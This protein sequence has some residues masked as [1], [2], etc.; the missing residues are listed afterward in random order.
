MQPRQGSSGAVAMARRL[1][2]SMPWLKRPLVGLWGLV[3]GRREKLRHQVS[4][5]SYQSTLWEWRY[6]A[7]ANEHWGPPV[8]PPPAPRSLP[9]E[10][11]DRFTMNGRIPVREQLG[12][13]TYPSNHPL[14]YTDAEIDY[15]IS[16][17]KAGAPF[18]YLGADIWLREAMSKYPVA[19]QSIAVMGS[20]TPW[21]EATCLAFGGRPFTIDYN[22]IIS[23]SARLEVATVAEFERNPR[24]F[25]AALTISSFEHD[26]LGMYGDPIDP[27]GDLKTMAKM[28]TVVKPG[29]LMYFSVPM[30]RD[31]LNFNVCRV[32]GRLRLPLMLR[33]WDV[34]DRFGFEDWHLDVDSA[35]EPIFVLR[36]APQ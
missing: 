23:K 11:L 15:Y 25:D 35:V 31:A 29:G 4:Y 10:M 5:L 22:P 6:R 28:K 3:F 13:G 30:G 24:V 19:G 21:Y 33:G 2:R 16:R 20:I 36:N 26:G 14:I 27:D 7:L 17:I 32:Y 9:K 12:D 1:L 34:V 8:R 18:L